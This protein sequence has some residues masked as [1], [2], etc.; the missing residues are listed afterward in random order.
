MQVEYNANVKLL[1]GGHYRGACDW[2]KE[3]SD[4]D[5]CYKLYHVLSGRAELRT[6]NCSFIL[7]AGCSYFINGY[8][9]GEQ[10]CLEDLEIHWLHF[11]P[12]SV[13]LN[14]LL[15]QAQ[16]VLKLDNPE[17]D[18]S[19]VLLQKAVSFFADKAPGVDKDP[20][21]LELIALIHLSIAGVFR[22][23]E[24]ILVEEET[25]LTRLMPAL[26]L[27]TRNFRESL[28]LKELADTCCLSANYFHRLFSTAFGMS[29][30][31]YVRMIR[32]EEAIRQL[33]Y[34]RKPVKQVAW[35]TGFEDE[36]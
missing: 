35:D 34:P 7:E 19:L 15:K 2:N 28:S 29:P 1:M 32:L 10:R 4:I 24:N 12:Q 14:H 20:L 13:Y 6:E 18:S 26:D 27:I 3:A 16:C 33:V 22:K 31:Y 8:I 30:L 25:V 36:S 23:M 11:Q 5:H 17:M 9:L 21:Q